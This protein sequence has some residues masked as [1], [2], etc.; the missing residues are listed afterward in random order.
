VPPR[1]TD[2]R[3]CGKELPE[4]SA[5]TR[6]Y[7]NATCR[8]NFNRAA[9]GKLSKG[10]KNAQEPDH[11][12][13]ARQLAM[14]TIGDEIREVLREEVRAS[15][16]QF[17]RD[18]VLGAAEVITLEALPKALK[19]LVED[20]DDEDWMVHSRATA[21]VMKYAMEFGK[22]DPNDK[23][24]T[25]IMI[26]NGVPTP[27]T[28]LGHAVAGEPSLLTTQAREADDDE[29]IV[30]DDEKAPEVIEEFEKDWPECYYC[31]HRK[32]PANIRWDSGGEGKARRPIC[33]SCTI[34]REWQK[35]RSAGGA[36]SVAIL[37]DRL[38]T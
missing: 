20:L 21:L 22:T 35:K 11:I 29:I 19:R 27:D 2:C 32:H 34:R 5:P 16:T 1:R 14:E 6:K 25:P 37:D 12:K 31:H 30:P 17:V 18:Q 28:P 3:W 13:S 24:Q 36:G 26:V 33:T 8:V 9:K 10:A 7:C 23:P 15:I 38:F 4:G